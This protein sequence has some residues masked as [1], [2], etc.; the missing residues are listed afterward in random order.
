[1][2]ATALDVGA[3]TTPP[4]PA[5]LDSA[6][7][8]ALATA[9]ARLPFNPLLPMTTF[10]NLA[11]GL[12]AILLLIGLCF[13]VRSL[14]RK[15]NVPPATT[16]AGPAKVASSLLRS[17]VGKPVL[18]A[19]PVSATSP[20]PATV[21]PGESATW[22]KLNKIFI[23][24]LSI[25]VP[26]PLDE[27]ATVLQRVSQS[28]DPDKTGVEIVVAPG[29]NPPP[30]IILQIQ[31]GLSLFDVL[32]SAGQIADYSF[33]VEGNQ[34]VL[35]PGHQAAPN[36]NA[37]AAT[38]LTLEHIAIPKVNI[39]TPTPLDQVAQTLEFL[40]QKSDP[41]GKG[42]NIALPSGIDSIPEIVLKNQFGQSLHDLLEAACKSAGYSLNVEGN[43]VMLRPGGG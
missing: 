23:P 18:P 13:I 1:M 4:S 37:T 38:W 21:N 32:E 42:V 43:L 10:K 2:L 22:S 28:F 20:A 5:L 15:N 6:V 16:F 27:I 11:I 31:S 12:A 17:T 35:R 25:D 41:T 8:H 14:D 34:V 26:T 30:K 7:D 24:K 36:D 39:D 3:K 29:N 9:K 40:S 33:T 19:T